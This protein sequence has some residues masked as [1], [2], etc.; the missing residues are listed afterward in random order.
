MQQWLKQFK[1]L[2]HRGPLIRV[3]IRNSLP[4]AVN[5]SL[6][7]LQNSIHNLDEL[8][9]A[10]VI[11]IRNPQKEL[12]YNSNGPLPFL[13]GQIRS[14]ALHQILEKGTSPISSLLWQVW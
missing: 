10:Q 9:A 3:N 11:Q 2:C 12:G 13:I 4:V 1:L 6:E 7:P 8:A 14:E 5:F